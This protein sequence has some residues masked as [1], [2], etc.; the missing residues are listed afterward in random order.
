[1]SVIDPKPP[2]GWPL[3]GPDSM[4]LIQ[5][6]V[7]SLWGEAMKGKPHESGFH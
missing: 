6:F 3:N 7:L 5:C 2:F 1:M 4:F